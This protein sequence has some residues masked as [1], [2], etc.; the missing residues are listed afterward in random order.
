MNTI[1]NK[2]D[3]VVWNNVFKPKNKHD[4]ERSMFINNDDFFILLLL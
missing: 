4:P 1:P 2:K 3:G